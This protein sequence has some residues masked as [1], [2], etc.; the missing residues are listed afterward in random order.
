MSEQEGTI[1]FAYQLQASDTPV[2]PWAAFA[3]LSAWRSILYELDLLGQHPH[4][5]GGFAYGNVSVRQTAD[6]AL[7]FVIS[8][9]QTSGA[10]SLQEEH[11][12]RITACNLSRFWVDAEGSEPPSSETITHA[13]VYAA[14]PRLRCVLHVHSPLIWHHRE[15]LRLPETAVD[16]GYG[17]PEMCQA[18]ATLM[19]QHQ[20]RPL[21]FATAGHED[22]IFACGHTLRDA[23]GLLVS[24]LAKAR[25]LAAEATDGNT[26][27]PNDE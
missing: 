7:G 24:Y 8:A 15:A 23:G 6:E 26:G 12:V 17:S 25:A 1:Q 27:A 13:M 11:L 19:E 5:Y 21:T 9:S 10:S 16:V 3:E 2:L 22:G 14:D 20:S 18:V 4:R